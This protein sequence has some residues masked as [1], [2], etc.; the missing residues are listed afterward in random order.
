MIEI[1]KGL[2]M[3]LLLIFILLINGRGLP[4]NWDLYMLMFSLI[5]DGFHFLLLGGNVSE[6]YLNH[7]I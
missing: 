7:V 5:N 6:K 1:K 3:N 4:V 2:W